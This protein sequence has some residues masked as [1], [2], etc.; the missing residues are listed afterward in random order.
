M[1]IKKWLA[2]LLTAAMFLSAGTGALAASKKDA[3]PSAQ[4]ELSGS[5][6]SE[7]IV[8]A[9]DSA[10]SHNIGAHSYNWYGRAENAWDWADPAQS[11]L[12]R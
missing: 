8:M 9:T 5:E 6:L 10:K 3:A 7:Y 2:L 4:R 11:F 12:A 1:K